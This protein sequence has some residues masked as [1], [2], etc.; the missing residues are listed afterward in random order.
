LP[1]DARWNRVTVEEA[2]ASSYRLTLH[3]PAGAG[4]PAQVK[5]DTSAVALALVRRLTVAGHHPADERM[6]IT[7][8]AREDEA[9][10]A[11]IVARFD[12][13]KDGIVFDRPKP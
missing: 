12:P 11:L 1:T 7:V 2:T 5:A 10:P 4:D 8:S 3:Y 6:A 9:G 13:D